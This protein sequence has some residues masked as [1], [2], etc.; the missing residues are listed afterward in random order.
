MEPAML[1]IIDALA[2][3]EDVALMEAATLLKEIIEA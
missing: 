2:L 1:R 3:A